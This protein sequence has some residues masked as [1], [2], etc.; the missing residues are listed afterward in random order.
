M[1]ISAHFNYHHFTGHKHYLNKSRTM[2]NYQCFVLNTFKCTVQNNWCITCSCTT[3]F[4]TNSPA[5]QCIHLNVLTNNWWRKRTVGFVNWKA[6]KPA[7]QQPSLFV[8]IHISQVEAFCIRLAETPRILPAGTLQTDR[9][10]EVRGL[11][12]AKVSTGR[13]LIIF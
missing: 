3:L 2:L 12:H 8:S 6:A 13:G 9:V 7:C 10:S 5:L 4:Q 1:I 11:L